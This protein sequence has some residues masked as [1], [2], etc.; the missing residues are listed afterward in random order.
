MAADEQRALI[1][2]L[3]GCGAVEPSRWPNADQST[4]QLEILVGF[5][6]APNFKTQRALEQ[7]KRLCQILSSWDE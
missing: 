3:L 4:F 6:W 7:E 2:R 5:F 1:G